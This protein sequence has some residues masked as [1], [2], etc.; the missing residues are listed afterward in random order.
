M[1]KIIFIFKNIKVITNDDEELKDYEAF[2]RS[3][4][5]DNL[6]TAYENISTSRFRY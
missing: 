2:L 4:A 6:A 1:A 3:E 5:Y